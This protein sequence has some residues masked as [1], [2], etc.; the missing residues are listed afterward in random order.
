MCLHNI[1]WVFH[2]V[3]PWLISKVQVTPGWRNAF[4]KS[5]LCALPQLLP[6]FPP[7]FPTDTR[8]HHTP[9]APK[10]RANFHKNSR[11]LNGGTDRRCLPNWA[12]YFKPIKPFSK[13]LHAVK[14]MLYSFLLCPRD[15]LTHILDSFSFVYIF[16]TMLSK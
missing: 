11:S 2:S 16:L 4:Q 13:S 12:S 14:C 7:T 10:K 8:T 1:T 9:P 5:P 15:E 3:F 6:P